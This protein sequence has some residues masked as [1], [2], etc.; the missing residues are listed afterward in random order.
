VTGVQTC[1]LPI[2]GAC[3]DPVA[4]NIAK[5]IPEPNLVP[6]SGPLNTNNYLRVPSRLD[7]TDAYTARGDAQLNSN[8]H[9]FIR[10]VYSNRFRFVPGA[11]G[12]VIDGTGTSAYG[13]QDLKAH[14]AAIGHTWVLNA[15]MLNE[16]RFG[17]GRNNSFAAQDPFGLNTLASIGIV[18][19]QDNPLYSG[20]LPGL[21]INQAA[22]FHSLRLDEVWDAWALRTFCRNFKRPINSKNRTRSATAL[23][24]I[25]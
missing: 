18:G 17:W 3:L 25:S 15:R 10:Y 22:V 7:N 23:A 12:G 6:G 13:R 14:S 8:Q 1:A 24:H 19:V 2:S 20:G 4:Q 5:L 11:F 21:S 9:L 16:F